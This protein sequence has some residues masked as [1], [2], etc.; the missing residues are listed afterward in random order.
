MPSGHEVA[1]QCALA[2]ATHMHPPPGGMGGA[3]IVS[4]VL[5]LALLVGTCLVGGGT[6]GGWVA[7]VVWQAGH[8][9]G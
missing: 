7:R 3:C 6:A 5:V 8:D 2:V 9:A 1:Q 4:G